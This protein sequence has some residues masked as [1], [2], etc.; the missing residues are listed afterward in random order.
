MHATQDAARRIMK[1]KGRVKFCNYVFKSARLEATA[2]GGGVA[3][4]GIARPC[5]FA[6]GFLNRLNQRRQLVTNKLRPKACDERDA[7]G[8]IGRL[9]NFQQFHQLSRRHGGA[10]LD[11]DRVLNAATILHMG[12]IELT[13]A[14][15][16]PWQM[17]AQIVQTLMVSIRLRLFPRQM[18]RLMAGEEFHRAKRIIAHHTGGFNEVHGVQD[19]LD[20]VLIFRA[21]IRAAHKGQIPMIR[22]M[23]VGKPAID[24]CTGIIDGGGGQMMR[25]HEPARICLTGFGNRRNVVYNVPTINGQLHSIDRFRV[26]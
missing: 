9:K 6:P 13:G 25:L 21:V 4:H 22:P 16:N 14:L 20:H 3:V 11:A 19:A 23:Q 24:Q 8:P 12:T 5:D 1:V 2:R 18:Q 7:P 17:R 10:D 15:T 26:V